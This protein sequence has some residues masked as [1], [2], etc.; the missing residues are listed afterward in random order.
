MKTDMMRCGVVGLSGYTGK[1]VFSLLLNHPQ[2]RITYVAAQNTTGPVS[3]IWP[4]FLNRTTLVCQK[5]SIKE[6]AKCCDVIFLGLPHTESMKVA[7]ALLKAGLKVIDL[8][9]DYRLKNVK[10]FETWYNHK[11]VDSKNIT[12]AVYGLWRYCCDYQCQQGS[13]DRQQ[14]K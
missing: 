2:V 6:A 13:H 11:H 8:S 1:E 9:A 10:T 7:G 4:E 12:K 14:I 3:S 5:F